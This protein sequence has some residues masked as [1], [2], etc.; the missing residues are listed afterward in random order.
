MD[1]LFG[2]KVVLGEEVRDGPG[3]DFLS[4]GSEFGSEVATFEIEDTVAEL[5]VLGVGDLA[6]DPLGEL[7]EVGDGPG[8]DKVKIAL[9]LLG[10][11]L[12][13][14]HILET[15]LFHHILHHFYFL[16]DGVD[17]IELG[18]GEKDGQRDAW[19]TASGAD[20]KHLSHGLEGLHLGDG[21]AVEDVVL[22]EM[23]HVLAGDDIDFG[24]PILIKWQ[25]SGKLLLL[26]LC[27]IGKV[28][29]YQFYTIHRLQVG[30]KVFALAA[31]AETLDTFL[32]DLAHTLAGEAK[33]HGNLVKAQG[34]GKADAEI[35]L[36]DLA[37]VL[38]EG[39]EST[40]NLLR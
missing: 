10:T 33:L 16:P 39:G 2:F 23:V 24:V 14:T 8:D 4:E 27:N 19:E 25:E 32:L 1:Y 30:L 35:H 15:K 29:Q 31:D 34:V 36:D 18:I 40:L 9:H 38:G 20:I 7:R 5:V 12:F 22:I 6:T 37:L 13:G 28:F 21:E 11:D 17:Q 3:A 26:P